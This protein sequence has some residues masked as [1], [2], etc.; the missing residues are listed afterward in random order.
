MRKVLGQ[1]SG[2]VQYRDK[3]AF[4][5]FSEIRVAAKKEIDFLLSFIKLSTHSSEKVSMGSG[6]LLFRTAESFPF[7]SSKRSQKESMSFSR[8]IFTDS[9]L[10]DIDFP[11][12][13]R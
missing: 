12:A 2:S 13:D 6:S 9:V 1:D 8:V 10:D 11:S 5:L 7:R 4:E 3:L